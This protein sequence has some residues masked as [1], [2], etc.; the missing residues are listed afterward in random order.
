MTPRLRIRPLSKTRISELGDGAYVLE[1]GSI[2]RIGATYE[3]ELYIDEIQP[4]GYYIQGD[5]F[6]FS[7]RDTLE[8]WCNRN[9]E[10]CPVRKIDDEVWDLLERGQKMKLLRFLEKVPE[11]EPYLNGMR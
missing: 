1:N 9:G 6:D 2:G 10:W 3:G 11:L 7:E 5:C 8:K 4:D